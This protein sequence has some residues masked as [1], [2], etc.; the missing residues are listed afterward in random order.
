MCGRYAASRRPE[1]LVVEFEAQDATDDRLLPLDFNVAPTKEV[2]VVVARHGVRQLRVARWGLVPSWAPDATG[3]ARLINA[4][5]ET[6]AERPAFRAALRWRRCLVP[7]DG[8]YEWAS[9]PDRPGRQ[10]YFITPADGS[11]LAFA[12]LY[13]RRE[14]LLTCTILTTAAT[15]TLS[16]V[17][18]RMPIVLDRRRW[19]AWLDPELAEPRLLLSAPADEVLGGLDLRPVGPAVGNVGNNGPDLTVRRSDVAPQTLF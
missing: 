15:G 9:G 10:P 17:H 6:V 8:W 19:A 5:V 16:E 4:R 13:E 3:G 12:G 14:G 1:D 2:H 18:D 11:V 7:A